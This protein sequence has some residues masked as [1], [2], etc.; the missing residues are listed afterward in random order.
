MMI[1]VIVTLWPV[2][3]GT[4][5]RVGRQSRLVCCCFAADTMY[6]GGIPAAAG[7]RAPS[8]GQ[9][10]GMDADDEARVAAAWGAAWC[11]GQL[12]GGLGYCLAGRMAMLATPAPSG[13]RCGLLAPTAAG[14][15]GTGLGE[16]LTASQLEEAVMS[17]PLHDSAVR[18]RALNH[19]SGFAARQ[20]RAGGSGSS[21]AAA[22]AEQLATWLQSTWG[23]H[24]RDLFLLC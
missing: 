3:C 9:Q 12:R 13:S 6:P 7:S 4:V 10:D 17:L 21:T 1:A 19:L 14:G 22:G 8:T 5:Q 18:L 24:A 15:R 16:G 2:A 23:H 11:S 20:R